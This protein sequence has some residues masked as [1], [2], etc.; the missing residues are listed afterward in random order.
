MIERLLVTGFEPYVAGLDVNP[1]WEI[2][3]AWAEPAGRAG[4]APG[5]PAI[6]AVRALRLPVHFGAA[7]RALE[8]AALAFRPDAIVCL[9]MHR[10]GP[11]VEVE[12]RLRF[13]G[14]AEEERFLEEAERS[15]L[16]ALLREAQDASAAAVPATV[17]P[18][19][20]AP[21]EPTGTPAA[22]P[23]PRA[24]SGSPAA[25][26]G[27]PAGGARCAAPLR[28]DVQRPDEGPL[29]RLARAGRTPA[30][31]T[32]LPVDALVAALG[33]AGLEARPSEDAGLYVCE[34]VGFVAL[35]LAHRLGCRAA[36]FIHVPSPADAPVEPLARRLPAAL[37]V[38]LA[39]A[40]G[41]T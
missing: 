2:A 20:A 26:E 29:A 16:A 17:A 35:S 12:R 39:R 25:T 28:D 40:G 8:E 19:L 36:G 11:A 38:A 32:R 23:I 31:E 7:A 37:G 21:P 30:R 33:E 14:R 18:P 10:R 9:G 3:R 6:P 27:P 4:T 1:S 15:A 5:S 24:G 13:A 41:A 22:G 34:H